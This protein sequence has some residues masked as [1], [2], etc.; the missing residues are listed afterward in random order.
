MSVSFP[1]QSA[2]TQ[3]FTLGAPRS[4]RVADDG[5]RVVYLRTRG[6]EDPVG[7]LWVL[8]LAAAEPREH[9]V[10]D[11]RD[12]R[13]DDS[14]LPPEERAR[15]ERSRESAG[16]I[17][18][19]A[20]DDGATVAAFAVGGQL[21]VA[22]LV[23]GGARA[24]AVS[25][26]VIDP[27]PSPDGERVA[28]VR[29]G[30]VLV[31]GI[32]GSGERRLAGDD[33]P[34]LTWGLAEFIA[35]EEMDRLRGYWWS[36][37][38]RQLAVAR[39]DTRPVQRW[40]IG[41][42][43]DPSTV[44]TAMAYPAAGTPN[45]DVSLFVVGLDGHSVEVAWD[46]SALPYLAEVVWSAPGPLTLVV[47]SRNQRER[48][49]LAANLDSADGTDT[50]A[51]RAVNRVTDERWVDLVPGVP[52]W[53]PDGQLVDTADEQDTRQLT[54]DGRPITPAGLQVRAAVSVTS[55]GIIFTASQDDP[56]AIAVWRV[57][58]G[59]EELQ[60]LTAP[61]EVAA[62]AG[63]ADTLVTVTRRFDQPG[64]VTEVR[65]R[66]GTFP[67]RSL[68]A[69][70]AIT[71]RAQLLRLG[72]RRLRAVLCL[73]SDHREGDGP[74]PVLLD[75]YGGPHAQRA[76]A[77]HDALLTSQWFADQGF[78][79]LVADGRG[80][81]GRGPAWERSVAGDLATAPLADQVDALTACA[82]AHPG[83]LNLERVAIRGWSFGGY[84]AALAVLRRPDVF[85]AAIAGAPVTDMALYDTHYTERYLGMPDEQPQAYAANSL[86]NDAASLRRPLLLIH[87]LADDNVVAAHTLR[88]SRA[89]LEAGRPHTVLPLSGVTHMTPQEEVAENLLLLQLRFLQDSLRVDITAPGQGAGGGAVASNRM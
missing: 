12:L 7:C 76:V 14:Q 22:D 48:V 44:P 16:G 68:A 2:R 80:T 74:L 29:D 20:T 8:D 87:G 59:G 77:S 27:R 89:L 42:P 24:L 10:A 66:L 55:E 51:A 18:A 5:S 70:P 11:P 78:A 31:A 39:V 64:A 63:D 52:C 26:P 4:F 71:T 86:L 23:A 40:H 49:V 65:H 15:R 9:C 38:S 28:F 6:G 67:V 61:D 35:A 3:R 85:A 53:L 73:P 41:D 54:V 56:A 13:A 75:P 82:D 36:P 30:A 62:A 47:Q 84:L 79:V 72:Q 83:L 43:A 17:V 45:A 58:V 46:R 21:F 69:T 34:E 19:F 60:R 32:D 57:G 1:R 33:D 81:P 37:D 88:L 50:G 25:G